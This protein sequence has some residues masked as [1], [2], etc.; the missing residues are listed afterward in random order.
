G[1]GTRRLAF[2]RFGNR[3]LGAPPVHGLLALPRGPCNFRLWR[4][5]RGADFALDLTRIAQPGLEIARR[6]LGE[7]DARRLDLSLLRGFGDEFVQ[8]ILRRAGGAA[9]HAAAVAAT[10]LQQ[11][12]HLT[13]ECGALLRI[14]RGRGDAR[15]LLFLLACSLGGSNALLLSLALPLSLE[16]GLA[17]CG[18]LILSAPLGIEFGLALSGGGGR[19]LLAAAFGIDFGFAPGDPP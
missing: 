13:H 12:L 10:L 1:T 2:P 16:F 8:R 11:L 6:G 15:A 19:F 17:L 9:V 18:S 3:A 5:R 4:R 14:E 7:V